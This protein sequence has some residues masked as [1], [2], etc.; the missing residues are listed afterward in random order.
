MK[1]WAIGLGAVM[2]L[3]II[4][5]AGKNYLSK[6]ASE[7]TLLAIKVALER[8]DDDD[9]A[10]IHAIAHWVD[11]K[12]E[13]LGAG[14]KPAQVASKLCEKV[15]L[16]SGKEGDIADIIRSVLLAVEKSAESDSK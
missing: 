12:T 11:K 5:K 16:L 4:L 7:Q 8:G 13:K 2:L 14:D 15:P 10:L 3:P 6:L 9:D 1:E